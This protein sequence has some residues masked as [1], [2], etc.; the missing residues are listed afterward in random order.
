VTR[1]EQP[2]DAELVARA[3][4]GSAEAFH[5]LVKRFE[6][7]VLSVIVRMV[8]DPVEA[9]DLA[10]ETFVKAYRHLRRYDP[11]RK[12]ASWLFKIAHNTTLDHLRRRRPEGVGPAVAAE[13]ADDG[14]ATIVP[15]APAAA[16]PDRIAERGELMAAL[17]TALGRIEP[18]YREALLLR[19]REGLSYL[20]IAD[21]LGLPINTVKVHLHRGRQRLA[22]AMTELGFD[23][24]TRRGVS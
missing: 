21:V 12:L 1:R 9:E 7:P 14:S 11:G 4:D 19:F 18:A 2:S 22:A 6:R 16:E 8:G 5:D 3:L 10:Q 15:E 17:D 13:P 23:E 20:E 24:T